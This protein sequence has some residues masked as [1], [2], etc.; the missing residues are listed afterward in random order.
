MP[1]D[2]RDRHLWIAAHIL[3]HEGE[4][5]GWLRRHAQTL[6]N[7]DI[8]DLVQEAYARLW[9]ADFSGIATITYCARP[10]PA[11]LG[12]WMISPRTGGKVSGQ[13]SM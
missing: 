1:N 6:S 13:D 11:M 3:P 10:D 7:A 4:V 9:V 2:D 12:Q 5:R 8:A